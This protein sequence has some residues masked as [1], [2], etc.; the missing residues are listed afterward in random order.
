MVAQQ[1][2]NRRSG[3][4]VRHEGHFDVGGALEHLEP[5]VC[6]KLHEIANGFKAG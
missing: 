2:V 5:Y 6:R 1:S 4:S 3:T